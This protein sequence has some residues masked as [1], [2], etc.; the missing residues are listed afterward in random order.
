MGDSPKILESPDEVLSTLQKDG[1]RR[2]IYPVVSKGA[3]LKR[4]RAV[5][6]SLVVLFV[7]LPWIYINGKPMLLLDV[8]AREFT[9]LG[10]T[11]Y[12]T[13]TLLFMT[14]VLTSLIG[15]FFV[16]ALFGRVW[17]GWACPQT[18][19]LEFVYRPVE[20]FFEGKASARRR[21]DEGPPSAERTLRKA[22]KWLTYTVIS[23]VLAHTFVAY[24]VGWGRLL[25]WMGGD[26]S[27]HLL[28]FGIM[29]LVSG[30]MLFD[31]GYFREQMCTITCPYA[32]LQS[33]LQDRDSMIVTYDP[34]RGE[35]RGN[36]TRA[37]RQAEKAGDDISLGDCIDCNACVRTCPTG[38][39]IRQGLQMEC[40]G[41]TQCIDACDH[42]ME[43]IGKPGGLIR[44]SSENQVER[45]PGRIARPRVFIYGVALAGLMI[46]LGVGLA[47]RHP[48]DFNI[49][50]A[51]KV[52][53]AMLPDDKVSNR[54][55]FRVQNRTNTTQEY[56]VTAVEPP[57]IEIKLVGRQT[58]TVGPGHTERVEGWIVAP[59]NLFDRGKTN[60]VFRVQDAQG[61]SADFA[62]TLLGPAS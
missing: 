52:P 41:C 12:A 25:E 54:L 30:L 40:I 36:R 17:C 5:G 1:A 23:V 51:G 7:A 35:P 49:G 28:F 19:Y 60:A 33:V 62:F 46:A 29:A 38:I 21:R 8:I 20:R 22:G 43:G 24:F 37:Q 18:V 2:W 6:L 55:R 61:T 26:P 13:D 4:R 57:G 50:R 11:F 15:I 3:W 34:V 42:I 9:I 47:N 14:I 48:I 32:R 10:V 16:T 53:F 44:Y 45:K 58:M 59:T 27:E 39:D 31:F 56:T